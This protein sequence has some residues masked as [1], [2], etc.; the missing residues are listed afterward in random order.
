MK[1]KCPVCDWDIT[2][3]GQRVKCDGGTVVV[4]CD[5]CAAKVKANAKKYTPAREGSKSHK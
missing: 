3:G 1:T 4:C 2:D 5:E